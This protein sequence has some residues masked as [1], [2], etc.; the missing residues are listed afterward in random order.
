MV[1]VEVEDLCFASEFE[2]R[3]SEEAWQA[4]Q[5]K[6]QEDDKRTLTCS[7]LVLWFDVHFSARVCPEKPVVLCT[8]PHSPP[9]HWH[10]TVLP[11]VT[12]IDIALGT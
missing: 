6:K 9:T 2:L 1:Q 12:P 11:L 8:A 4:Q 10:H 7:S 5:E 3:P